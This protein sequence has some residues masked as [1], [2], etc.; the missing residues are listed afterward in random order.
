MM[1]DANQII[2]RRITPIGQ[3]AGLTFKEQ[4][5]IRR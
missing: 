1:V 4:I 2:H 5:N 3:Q